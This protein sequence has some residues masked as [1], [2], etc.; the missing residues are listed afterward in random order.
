MSAL[1]SLIE[2]EIPWEDE[3]EAEEVRRAE[4]EEAPSG[5]RLRCPQCGA[6]IGTWMAP[7]FSEWDGEALVEGD[8]G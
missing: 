2:G 1:R 3:Q 5:D 8:E 7:G 6:L 4:G